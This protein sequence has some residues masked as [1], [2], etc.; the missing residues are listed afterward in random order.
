MR[1]IDADYGIAAID[2]GIATDGAVKESRGVAVH[3]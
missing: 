2:G 3:F 1:A